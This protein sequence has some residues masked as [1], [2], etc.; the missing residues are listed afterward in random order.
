MIFN[1]LFLG[2]SYTFGDGFVAVVG[3]LIVCLTVG[4]IIRIIMK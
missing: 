1:D 4:L 2:F 3:I